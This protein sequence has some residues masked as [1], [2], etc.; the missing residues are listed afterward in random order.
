MLFD[1]LG[2]FRYV[3]SL[4]LVIHASTP[5]DDTVRPLSFEVQVHFTRSSPK[6]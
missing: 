5:W 6:N 2:G 3:A 1:K 4:C